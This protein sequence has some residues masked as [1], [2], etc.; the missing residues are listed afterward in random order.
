MRHGAERFE[1]EQDTVS[2]LASSAC[3][4]ELEWRQRYQAH[5]KSAQWKNTRR[6]LF[7]LR[8]RKCE[9]CGKAA[10]SLEV[11][12]LNYERLGKELPSDLQIVCKP[13]HEEADRKRESKVARKRKSR[14]V[15]N[16]FDTW[17]EKKTGYN[18]WYATEAD[19]EEFDEWLER[20]EGEYY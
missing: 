1:L 15:A 16:A 6:D 20:K 3:S 4:A 12:H 7:R 8:G 11:H 5:L 19:Y 9:L 13:C 18:P 2:P 17:F 14:R 10:A